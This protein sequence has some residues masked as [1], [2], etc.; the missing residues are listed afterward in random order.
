M[1]KCYHGLLLQKLCW[2]IRLSPNTDTIKN[3]AQ[4]QL[5]EGS[6]VVQEDEQSGKEESGSKSGVDGADNAQGNDYIYRNVVATGRNSCLAG[7]E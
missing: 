4:K 2:H 5:G 3:A 6:T 1:L 7:S